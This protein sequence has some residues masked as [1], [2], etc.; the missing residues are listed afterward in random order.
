M[1]N[2]V[3]RPSRSVEAGGAA[4]VLKTCPRCLRSDR[5]SLSRYANLGSL[6]FVGLTV[7]D[8]CAASLR[9]AGFVLD[10]LEDV[11]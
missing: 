8:D 9:A 4:P 3:G 10:Y 1:L 7:C 5:T 6:G 2:P 11:A